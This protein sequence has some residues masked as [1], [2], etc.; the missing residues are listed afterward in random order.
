MCAL[1]VIGLTL[2]FEPPG[3]YAKLPWYALRENYFAA[4]RRA[5]DDAQGNV[6]R[7]VSGRRGWVLPGLSFRG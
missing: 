5:P 7:F 3:G 1:P 6:K 2:D 4:V